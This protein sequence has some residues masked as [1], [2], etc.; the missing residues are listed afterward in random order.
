LELCA[1]KDIPTVRRNWID[2]LN[3]SYN[4]TP[5]STR[6]LGNRSPE[7]VARNAEIG[8]QRAAERSRAKAAMADL[9]KPKEDE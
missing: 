2:Q 1:E 8:R 4:A 7:S 9:K 5:I 6:G 3:P